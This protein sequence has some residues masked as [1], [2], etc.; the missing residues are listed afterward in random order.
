MGAGV[1]TTAMLLYYPDRYRN[2]WIIFADTGDEMPETYWYVDNYLKPFCDKNN[3]KWKTVKSY[4]A[5]SLREYFF[6]KKALPLRMTRECT[7]EFKVRPIN[8][9]MREMGARPKD[10]FFLDIGFSMDE[11]LR[12]NLNTR[13]EIKSIKKLFPLLDDKLTRKDCEKIITDY[14]WPLP[15]K[16]GCDWCIFKNRASFRKLAMERP[17]RFKQIVEFEE[18]DSKFPKYTLI[19]GGPLRD[20]LNEKTLDTFSEDETCDSGHCFR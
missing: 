7:R 9:F 20:I 17:E 11:A 18:N 2:G 19:K 4:K 15:V 6:K 8:R 3:L 16:S 13:Y 5:N 14:G 10:P 12:A 1:Q